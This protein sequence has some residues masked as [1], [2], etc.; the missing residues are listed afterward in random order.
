L[1]VNAAELL[2]TTRERHGLS[3]VALARRASTTPRQIG[4]IERGEISPSVGTLDRLLAAMG[5]Q[6]ELGAVTA[7]GGNQSDAEL[8]EALAL[9]RIERVQEAF[10]LSETLTHVASRAR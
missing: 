7:A 4:R 1:A 10:A 6:L 3:Q 9:T 8:R 2:R 5:E